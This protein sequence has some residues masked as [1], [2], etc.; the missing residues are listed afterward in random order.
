MAVHSRDV[1]M[2]VLGKPC[3]ITSERSV[4]C[5]SGWRGAAGCG[6]MGQANLD[7]EAGAAAWISITMK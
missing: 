7:K 3:R 2:S 5:R 4:I 1:M 6:K